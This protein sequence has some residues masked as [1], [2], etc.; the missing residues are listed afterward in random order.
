[1]FK[2]N[3]PI[4]RTENDFRMECVPNNVKILQL[5]KVLNHIKSGNNTTPRPSKHEPVQKRSGGTD[6]MLAST[7]GPSSYLVSTFLVPPV[8]ISIAL[9][10]LLLRVRSTKLLLKLLNKAVKELLGFRACYSDSVIRHQTH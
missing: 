4:V 8:T 9:H 1:M 10:H 5:K 2:S 3:A 7:R 6:E